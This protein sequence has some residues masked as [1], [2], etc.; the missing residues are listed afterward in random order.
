MVRV[1]ILRT[2]GINCDQETAHAFEIAGAD[3]EVLHVGVFVDGAR[4]LDEFS[5][6]VFPGGFSYGDDLGAG[7][8]FANELRAYLLPR[9]H[10]FVASGRLVLGICNGFQVLVRLGLLPGWDDDDVKS[11]SLVVNES[12]KF[13]DRWV[14]LR[15]ESTRC[16]FLSPASATAAA[17]E[18]N[19]TLRLP[20]AHR[21]GR[22]AVRAP[23]VLERLE[24]GGQVALRY[25]DAHGAAQEAWSDDYPANP[26][27]SVH[28]IAGITNP[29]GNVLGMMPHPERFVHAL[30]DPHWTRRKALSGRGA[31]DSSGGDGLRF[32]AS[33]VTHA[34]GL[35]ADGRSVARGGKEA[36]AE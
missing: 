16:P 18:A 31:F 35:S 24:N 23:E 6:V 2:A 30:H 8:V 34:K 20:V 26:N 1:L 22:L 5:V 13:E 25:V 27:G 19:S 4:S 33:A 28:G 36:E 10:E 32:F 21:E 17:T 7:T 29:A 9:L 12:G 11:L 3:V 15:A 14:H